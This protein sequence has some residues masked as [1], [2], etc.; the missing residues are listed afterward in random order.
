MKE[1]RPSVP[2]VNIK[3]A[4]VVV[5]STERVEKSAR[6]IARGGG[7]AAAGVV[8]GTSIFETKPS[9]QV[10]AA[11]VWGGGELPACGAPAQ[12]RR[13]L[14]RLRASANA[15]RDAGETPPR[16]A[17]RSPFVARALPLFL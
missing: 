4:A 13:R 10:Q 15:M 8:T 9:H 3:P 12:H 11:L 16:T 1:D 6:S 5:G 17:I 2:L 14:A 7:T